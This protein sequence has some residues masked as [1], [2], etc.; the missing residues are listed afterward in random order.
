MAESQLSFESLERFEAD[1]DTVLLPWLDVNITVDFDDPTLSASDPTR[2]LLNKIRIPLDLS[3]AEANL[4]RTTSVFSA[5][6][7]YPDPTTYPSSTTFPA[8]EIEENIVAYARYRADWIDGSAGGHPHR[9]RRHGPH[10]SRHRSN[11]Q[12]GRHSGH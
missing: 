6:A 9:R 2:Y 5:P 11:R 10:R 12:R 8:P 7:L 3:P 1:L 4:A